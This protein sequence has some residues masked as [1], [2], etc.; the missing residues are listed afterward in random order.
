MTHFMM[1]KITKVDLT[2]SHYDLLLAADPSSVCVNAYIDQGSIFEVRKQGE[3]LAV[4]V[5]QPI[6]NDKAMEIKNISV[7]VSF[8]RQGLGTFLLKEVILQAK[9]LGYEYL[10]IGTGTTSF[11]QLALYQKLGF[12]FEEIKKDFFSHYPEPLYE[13]NI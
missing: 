10:Y 7:H 6:M 3:L 4:L 1:K 5:L 2:S 9:T 13:N 8:Q 11:H 12:R